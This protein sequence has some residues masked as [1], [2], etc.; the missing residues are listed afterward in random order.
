MVT[1]TQYAVNTKQDT[2]YENTMDII[3]GVGEMV[4]LAKAKAGATKSNWLCVKALDVQI[5]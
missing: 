2:S 1:V 4:F 3:S 5:E